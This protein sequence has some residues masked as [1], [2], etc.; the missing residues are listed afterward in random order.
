MTAKQF[1]GTV[2]IGIPTAI[3]LFSLAAKFTEISRT[4]WGG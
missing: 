2:M 4:V 1:V 3:L